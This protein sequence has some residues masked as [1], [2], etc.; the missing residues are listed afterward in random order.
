MLNGRKISVLS[1]AVKSSALTS[2][3]YRILFRISHP[4]R[5]P[6]RGVYLAGWDAAP[7][8]VFRKHK[9]GTPR[10]TVRPYYEGLPSMAGRGADERRRKLPGSGA[11]RVSVRARKHGPEVQSR[12]QWSAARCARPASWD[13]RRRK[14]S[15]EYVAPRGAPLPRLREVSKENSGAPALQRTGS[16]SRASIEAA[17]SAAP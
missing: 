8:F 6:S 10:V 3:Y 14:A 13:A 17:P 7:A 16:M 12:R 15:D 1:P 2:P 5:A 4:Q 9:S 11:Q